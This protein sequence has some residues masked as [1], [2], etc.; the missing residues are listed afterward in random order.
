MIHYWCNM[1]WSV[2]VI[3][4]VCPYNECEN[5][6]F[7]QLIS[8]DVD[9]IAGGVTPGVLLRRKKKSW[10]CDFEHDEEFSHPTSQHSLLNT[11]K[12]HTFWRRSSLPERNWQSWIYHLQHDWV[13]IVYRLCLGRYQTYKG[14][15]I[16]YWTHLQQHY[17][18]QQCGV[19]W[20]VSRP[21]H[22]LL[23]HWEAFLG[24]SQTGGYIT[25]SG[26]IT[27]SWSSNKQDSV[28]TSTT[29]AEYRSTYEDGQD[30]EW[31]TTL[32]TGMKLGK[33]SSPVIN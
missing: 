7:A 30:I 27:V 13:E 10:T 15:K 20:R 1:V 24:S 23:F 11:S 31:G 25:M 16:K 32:L 28:A 26:S 17:S 29:E 5:E 19:W 6:G 9:P 18:H 21:L 3:L 22:S 33:R 4:G 14:G 2:E 8:C 12:N